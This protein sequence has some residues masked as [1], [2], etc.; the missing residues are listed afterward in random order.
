MADGWMLKARPAYYL[1]FARKRGEEKRM[2]DGR[3]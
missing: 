3:P 1:M 2:M